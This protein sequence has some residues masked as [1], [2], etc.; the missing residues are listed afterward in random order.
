MSQLQIEVRNQ[1]TY[2]ANEESIDG[3]CQVL[4]MKNPSA[5]GQIDIV[6]TQ[7]FNTCK[8]VPNYLRSVNLGTLGSRSAVVRTVLSGTPQNYTFLSSA[9]GSYVSLS[10]VEVVSHVNLTLAAVRPAVGHVQGPS[11][12]E[13]VRNL[14]GG[15]RTR[16]ERSANE[17]PTTERTWRRPS[18]PK[19]P[20]SHNVFIFYF[21]Y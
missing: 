21:L 7:N 18:E 12:P 3:H 5:K 17:G 4:Y 11:D 14:E 13:S 6:K 20:P 10:Q 16:G 1:E 19:R 2:T 15:T 9:A 8:Q